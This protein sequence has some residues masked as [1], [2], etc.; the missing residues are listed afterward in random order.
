M[1]FGV[2]LLKIYEEYD[3]LSHGL[4]HGLATNL[5]CNDVLPSMESVWDE[6]T[7]NSPLKENCHSITNL[8]KL[9]QMNKRSCFKFCWKLLYDELYQPNMST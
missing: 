8:K 4:N 6:L 3:I 5:S 9:K 2:Y 1:L 7:R